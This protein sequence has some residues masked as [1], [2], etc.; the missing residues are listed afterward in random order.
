MSMTY[1]NDPRVTAHADGDFTIHTPKGDLDI[2]HSEA[3]LWCAFSVNDPDVYNQ[4]VG[5]ETADEL[6]GFLLG[7]PAR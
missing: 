2:Q 4:L 6:I 1:D 7:E 5:Y 3:M